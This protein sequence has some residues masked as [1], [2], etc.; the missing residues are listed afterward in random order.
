MFIRKRKNVEFAALID[1]GSGSV[2]VSVVYSNI[3]TN[4]FEII[5]SHRENILLKQIHNSEGTTKHIMTAYMNAVLTLGK[6][7]LQ[8]LYTFDN[9]AVIKTLQVSVSAPWSYT[10]SKRA[11]I[12]KEDLF[13]IT[14]SLIHELTTAAEE[15][16]TDELL[17]NE[18]TEALDLQTVNRSVAKILANG[19]E[20]G[21]VSKQKAKSLELRL[22]SVVIQ[23]HLKKTILESRDAVL[24]KAEVKIFSF[25]NM[26]YYVL[27]AIRPEMQE[28][29]IVNQTFEATEI[30]IVRDGVLTYSTHTPFGIV[31]YAR[32]IANVLGITTEEVFGLLESGQLLPRIEKLTKEKKVLCQEIDNQYKQLLCELL[33]ETGDGFTIPKSIFLQTSPKMFDYFKTTIDSATEQASG[34]KHIVHNLDTEH[35]TAGE[36]ISE[37][38]KHRN[39]K[40]VSGIFFH[41]YCHDTRFTQI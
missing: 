37:S 14:P 25:V 40:W 1:I 23:K 32:N 36:F 28:Y 8:T 19:Y 15:K 4:D 2:S 6:E 3:D 7:G 39:V 5:W 27:C 9:K 26:I 20:L 10:I 33:A 16:I 11:T 35:T 18:I 12:V 21:S 17:E 30:G 24:P 31:T 38:L 41:K 13:V 29:C 34:F 22:L